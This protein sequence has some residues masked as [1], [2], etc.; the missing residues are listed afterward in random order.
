MSDALSMESY[1]V[2]FYPLNYICIKITHDDNRILLSALRF[3]LALD[4]HKIVSISSSLQVDDI[5]RPYK[6]LEI[7]ILL[8]SDYTF[9]CCCCCCCC[10]K[11]TYQQ[12]QIKSVT[13]TAHE[14]AKK[15]QHHRQQRP[16]AI[17]KKKTNKEKKQKNK[18]KKKKQSKNK[19]KNEKTSK[20]IFKPL[21]GYESKVILSYLFLLSSFH[22]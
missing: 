5:H 20:W 1:H 4:L 17:A 14:K 18:K 8:K 13:K 22:N 11:N 15:Y 7:A 6:N 19:K 12:G 10:S 9:C 21:I 16:K 3:L 2:S